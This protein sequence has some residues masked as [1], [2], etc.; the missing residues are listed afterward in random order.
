MHRISASA[1]ALLAG[2]TVMKYNLTQCC[3]LHQLSATN[4][5]NRGPEPP[6]MHAPLP[7]CRV[8]RLDGRPFVASHT[9]IHVLYILILSSGLLQAAKET[10][11]ESS[12]EEDSDEEESE[13]EEAPKAKASK[14]K[15]E[16]VRTFCSSKLLVIGHASESVVSSLTTAALPLLHMQ[17]R[18]GLLCHVGVHSGETA[19]VGSMTCA[20]GC[21]EAP[22]DGGSSWPSHLLFSRQRG[23][24]PC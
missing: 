2:L 20:H 15:A 13:E 16:E 5:D 12:E 4:A 11:E 24:E 19:L 17:L 3:Y 22:P 10:A 18:G 23:S 14:R 21:D 6:P 8:R 1:H 9:A 7:D